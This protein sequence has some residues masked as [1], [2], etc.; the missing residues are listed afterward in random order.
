MR[1]LILAAFLAVAA[2]LHPMSD[3]TRI[4]LH[5]TRVVVWSALPDTRV[6]QKLWAYDSSCSSGFAAPLS[7]H[8]WR[9][10]HWFGANLE[11]AGEDSAAQV[12]TSLGIGAGDI[13]F[14]EG[15]SIFLDT[16]MVHRAAPWYLRRVMAHEL[17]HQLL[18]MRH[19]V[20][21][22]PTVLLL[23]LPIPVDPDSAHPDF[24]FQYP[25]QLHQWNSPLPF[26]SVG[27]P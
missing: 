7:G 21:P 25:C 9:N 14:W 4:V 13:G 27:A 16:G 15:D 8:G 3:G 17:E 12:D 19:P 2:A 26:D 10:V 18:Q 24:P 20:N 1:A 5:G 23:G 6:V 22:H 11:E